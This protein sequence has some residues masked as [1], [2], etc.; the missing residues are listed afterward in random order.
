[1]SEAPAFEEGSQVGDYTFGRVLGEGAFGKVQLGK[2][3]SSETICAIKIVDKSAF[4]NVDDVERVYRETFILTKLN[5][6]N[7]IRLFETVSSPDALLIVMEYAGG[8]ELQQYVETRNRLDECDANRIFR[9][10][11]AGVEYC[12]RERI[13]HRDLKPENV[14]FTEDSNICKIVDFGLSNI[15]RWGTKMGTNCGTPSFSSPEQVRGDENIGP[16]T[17]IWSLGV[18][19]Y[20]MI[21]GFLPFE[22]QNLSSLF[23]KIQG[24]FFT[25]PDH[26]SREAR[27]LI[28]R[29][30]VT[31]A[32]SRA[33]CAAIKTSA[34]YLFYPELVAQV[35]NR[36]V[37]ALAPH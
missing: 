17:D 36:T 33:S 22:A 15:S 13:V 21:C 23:K 35:E 19:L 29:L 26:V 34:W 8:G 24:G 5:H 10:L 1:M 14:L 32:D 3:T 4:D 20:F 2:H 7:V 12:H 11:V 28:H 30:L 18:I 31:T 6:V 9:Q 16:E 27:D 25:F 37:S